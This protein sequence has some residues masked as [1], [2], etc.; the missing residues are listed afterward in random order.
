MMRLPQTGSFYSVDPDCAAF[1]P[2]VSK[3]LNFDFLEAAAISGCAVF[4]SVTPGILTPDEEKRM[5]A[6]LG[7]AATLAPAEYAIPTDWTR[8]TAPGEYLFRGEKHSYDW[9][10]DYKGARNILTWVE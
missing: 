3:D 2:K 8:T 4:A 6:I 9:Y 10:R 5:S 1:T 7:T